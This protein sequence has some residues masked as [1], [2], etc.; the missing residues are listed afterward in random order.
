MRRDGATSFRDEVGTIDVLRVECDEC[1]RSSG[2]NLDRSRAV[3]ST[4]NYS[5]GVMRSPPIAGG[6]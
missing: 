3:A 6:A 1:G 4:P 5:I 2:Q